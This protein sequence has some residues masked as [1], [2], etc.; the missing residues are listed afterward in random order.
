MALTLA[1]AHRWQDLLEE[2]R[3]ATIRA[4]AKDAPGQSCL[5]QIRRGGQGGRLLKSAYGG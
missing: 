4:L 5:R 2:G 1:R 3:Y